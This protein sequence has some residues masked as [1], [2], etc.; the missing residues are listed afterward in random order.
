MMERI[1]NQVQMVTIDIQEMI[2]AQRLLKQIEK[3]VS[4]EFIYGI[5]EPYY[6]KKG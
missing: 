1:S 3:A 4:F 5:A 2:P 6:A